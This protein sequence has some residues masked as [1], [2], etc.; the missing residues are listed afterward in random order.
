MHSPKFQ[1]WHTGPERLLFCP[2]NPGAGKTVLAA[3]TANFLETH[4]GTSGDT[5]HVVCIFN[6]YKTGR[7][8]DEAKALGSVLRQL[9]ESDHSSYGVL[10]DLYGDHAERQTYP[11][12]L[13]MLTMIKTAL[14][15][16]GTVYLLVD[17]LD[18]ITTSSGKRKKFLD[19][20]FRLYSDVKNIR[21][22]VTC[23]PG[24]DILQRFNGVPSVQI[25][26]ATEDITAYI[27]GR[28]EDFKAPLDDGFKVLIKDTVIGAAHGM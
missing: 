2:G 7:N 18:E 19:S 21:V 17:A 20:L 27:D 25:A 3:R 28:F 16:L 12:A 8:F 14:S 24:P 22:M 26:A 1:Q 6:E 9:M 15:T 4:A 5:A 23:R 13:E 11:S 10:L